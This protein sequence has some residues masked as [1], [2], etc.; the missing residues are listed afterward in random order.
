M[1]NHQKADN[2]Q[3]WTVLLVLALVSLFTIG[4]TLC[5]AELPYHY[6]LIGRILLALPVIWLVTGF[7]CIG[8]DTGWNVFNWQSFDFYFVLWIVPILFLLLFM[9][10]EKE[11]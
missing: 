2:V 11:E 3:I 7:V 1:A 9:S 4:L 10:K 8:R 5:S 6:L